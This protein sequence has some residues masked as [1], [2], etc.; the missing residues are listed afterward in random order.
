MEADLQAV[1]LQALVE[2]FTVSHKVAKGFADIP[3]A[4]PA[5]W[6]RSTKPDIR[7]HGARLFGH[8]AAHSSKSQ[9]QA[10]FEDFSGQCDKYFESPSDHGFAS[11]H[12]LALVWMMS[13]QR[14]AD[15]DHVARVVALV[16]RGLMPKEHVSIQLTCAE[17]WLRALSICFCDHQNFSFTLLLWFFSLSL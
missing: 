13:Q 15:P 5:A 1:S 10:T 17:V 14:E 9:L 12:L 3:G 7:K 11:G 16:L 2:L 4:W 8:M 6:L